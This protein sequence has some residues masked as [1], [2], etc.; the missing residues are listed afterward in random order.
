MQALPSLPDAT[1]LSVIARRPRGPKSEKS[2]QEKQEKNKTNM[3][4][5]VVPTESFSKAP[6]GQF[7]AVCC[8][9]VDLG[10]SQKTYKNQQTGADEQRNVH[11]IQYIFQINKVDSE[12]GKRYEVRSK[13][14]NLILSEK[15]SLRAFLLQWRGHDLL[16]A[17]LKPP[18][19]DVDLTGRNA[20]LQV[21]H[22]QSGDKTYA[23]IGAIM[24]LMEGMAEIQALD[25]QPKQDSITA[26]QNAAAAGAS[27]GSAQAPMTAPPQTDAVKTDDLPF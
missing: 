27:N 15:A 25:Y 22:N 19:V 18:G 14:F 26:K 12:T 21:V 6:A 17:E 7:Q 10:Y 24:P 2:K 11:E 4:F 8:E 23:N 1:N 5:Q 13:P 3:A 9:V 16:P 20:L